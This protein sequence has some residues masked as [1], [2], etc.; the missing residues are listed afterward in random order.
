MNICHPGECKGAENCRK[1]VK[2]MCSCKTR[3]LDLTCDKVRAE[4]IT[5]LECNGECME[6]KRLIEEENQRKILKQ[7]QIEEEKNRRELEE[8]EKKF[9]PKKYKERKQRYV[10]EEKSNVKMKVLISSTAFIALSIAIYFI[11]FNN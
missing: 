9:G 2:L 3:K 7:Q 6:K 11:F 4:N 10:E 8:Y 1:K 5:V